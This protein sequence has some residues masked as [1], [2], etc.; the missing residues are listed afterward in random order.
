MKL[1]HKDNYKSY[2]IGL[3]SLIISILALPLLPEQIPVH[4]NAQGIPD[5][6][7]SHLTVF[8]FPAIIL[9]IT[10]LGEFTKHTDPRAANYSAFSRHYYLFFLAI[11]IFMFLVQLYVISYALEWIVLNIST[12]IMVATGILFIIIGNLLPKIKQNYFMGIKT[13]WALADEQVWYATHRFTGKLWFVAGIF[14][15][16]CGFLPL[17]FFAPAFIFIMLIMVLVP[18]IYSYIIFKKRSD[19]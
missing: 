16:I 18:M 6:Y 11:N 1:I 2:I 12:L 13:P 17:K 8:I 10:I 3:I 7:G 19:K 14:L 4:F 15:C 9:F 5:G